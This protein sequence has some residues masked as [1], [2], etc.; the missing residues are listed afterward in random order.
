MTATLYANTE[1]VA[2]TWLAETFDPNM[3]ATNLPEDNSTWSAS[4]FVQVTAMGGG[5]NSDVPMMHPVVSIDCWA[6]PP[7]TSNRPPFRL[8]ANNAER[9]RRAVYL[10][11]PHKLTLPGTYPKAQLYTA[12]II[13][14]PRRIPDPSSYARYNMAVA[15][16]WAPAV[17][18]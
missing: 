11:R 7:V 8:A 3:I 14:E 12:D 9:I 10:L 5:S 15:M 6:S 16:Y 18:P 4:G 1:L 13:T 2:M 17:W